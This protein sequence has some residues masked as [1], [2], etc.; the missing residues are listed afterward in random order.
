VRC[1][2]LVA[3][4]QYADLR[5]QLVRLP[6]R[7]ADGAPRLRCAPRQLVPRQLVPLD[8]SR[9]NLL[10][11]RGVTQSLRIDTEACSA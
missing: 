9:G 10:N 5:L 6:T 7:R 4:V 8:P 2:R 1:P 3:M 11:S